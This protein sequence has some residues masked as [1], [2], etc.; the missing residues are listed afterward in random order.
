MELISPGKDLKVGL[1]RRGR[2]NSERKTADLELSQLKGCGHFA[3]V[4]K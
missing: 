3:L 4:H 1:L 2:W